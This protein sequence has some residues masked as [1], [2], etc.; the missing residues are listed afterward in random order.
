M[1]LQYD[2]IF[3]T[4]IGYKA[5][6]YY[7]NKTTLESTMSTDIKFVLRRKVTLGAK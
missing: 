4:V 5:M 2:V 7:D 6:L 3:S 1:I